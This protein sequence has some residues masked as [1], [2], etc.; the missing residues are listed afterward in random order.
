[1]G[2]FAIFLVEKSIALVE[3]SIFLVEKLTKVLT[4]EINQAEGGEDTLRGTGDV[5]TCEGRR[6]V[7][8]MSER[9]QGEVRDMRE[10]N[11]MNVREM[12]G[13]M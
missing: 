4:G 2:I 7:R 10:R 6:N 13:G 11:E 12:R 1:M 8:A 9:W 5:Y 3:K